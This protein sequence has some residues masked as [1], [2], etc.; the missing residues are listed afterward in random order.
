MSDLEE[1]DH[2]CF[3]TMSERKDVIL[4]LR[5]L[6]ISVGE[7][8]WDKHDSLQD[9]EDY[10]ILKYTAEARF[11]VSVPTFC[12]ELRNGYSVTEF[13]KKAGSPKKPKDRY[14]G[15]SIKHYFL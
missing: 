10:P 7:F 2:C 14:E 11:I 13:I 15:H 4:R 9:F 3:T 1:G 5:S 6:G 8:T 12:S